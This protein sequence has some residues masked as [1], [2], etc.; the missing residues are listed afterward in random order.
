MAVT[1]EKPSSS[2]RFLPTRPASVRER[3]TFFHD[4]CK[5]NK[6]KSSIA[7]SCAAFHYDRKTAIDTIIIKRSQLFFRV[8]PF[9]ANSPGQTR[10]RIKRPLS[11]T[12]LLVAVGADLTPPF[13]TGR[14]QGC[15]KLTARPPPSR[16]QP[17]ITTYPNV[18]LPPPPK[19]AAGKVPHGSTTTITKN[20]EHLPLTQN[21]TV[22]A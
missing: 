5:S 2:R 10:P 21:G 15:Q 18:D 12:C 19:R 4:R 13:K 11:T 7:T 16:P 17:W 3:R 14:G 6:S 8:C 9:G 22:V 1:A 20:E